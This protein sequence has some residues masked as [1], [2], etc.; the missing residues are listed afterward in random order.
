MS[1]GANAVMMNAVMTTAAV[2]EHHT[3]VQTK[4]KLDTCVLPNPWLET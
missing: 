2:D 4:P 1:M 3:K